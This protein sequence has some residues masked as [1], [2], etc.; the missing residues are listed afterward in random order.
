M[1]RRQLLLP[2][3]MW[4]C[5]APTTP[6]SAVSQESSPDILAGVDSVDAEVVLTWPE[7]LTQLD[8]A[9]TESR[10]Q[11]V[12]QLELRKNGIVVSAGA[13]NY[14]NLELTLLNNGDGSV[15]YS[16]AVQLRE[17]GLPDR[18]VSQV[19]VHAATQMDPS[20]MRRMRTAD[21]V[22]AG[23]E[24]RSLMWLNFM[25]GYLPHKITWIS[26]WV[27][28]SGVGHVGVQ[29]LEDTLERSAIEAAQAFANAYMANRPR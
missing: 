26:S 22:R 17:P 11:T 9:T 29:N 6:A 10:L 28:P 4:F 7:Q 1:R 15:S 5:F 18:V 12:F 21:S 20:L 2:I 25:A 24:F 23:I 27:G 8:K 16:Y 14:L 13:V 19:I 3:V